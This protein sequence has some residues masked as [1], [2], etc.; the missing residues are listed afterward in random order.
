MTSLTFAKTPEG[1]AVHRMLSDMRINA[2][3]NIAFVCPTSIHGLS[4]GEGNHDAL[5]AVRRMLLTASDAEDFAVKLYVR[6]DVVRGNLRIADTQ[7]DTERM[8]SL[9]EY[10]SV[11]DQFIAELSSNQPE[12]A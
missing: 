2:N 5:C 8:T 1:Q 9:A 4:A 3:N 10:E 6:R 11:L 12:T 7:C